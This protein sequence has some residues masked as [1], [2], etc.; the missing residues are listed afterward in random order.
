MYRDNDYGFIK[1]KKHYVTSKKGDVNLDDVRTLGQR[2][3]K[4]R[5]SICDILSGGG[6]M[7][8]HDIRVL[9][10]QDIPVVDCHFI[11][12]LQ[13]GD[14]LQTCRNGLL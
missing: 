9:E 14:D 5:T 2:D 13:R 8:Y 1:R 10:H 7:D 6:E 3:I 12:P 11:G 4:T